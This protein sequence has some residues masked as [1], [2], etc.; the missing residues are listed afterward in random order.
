M[1]EEIRIAVIS[2]EVVLTGKMYEESF[3][4]DGNVVRS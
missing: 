3:W 4:G 1:V 2:G